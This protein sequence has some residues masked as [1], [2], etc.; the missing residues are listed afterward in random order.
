MLVPETRTSW[1]KD[2]A[3]E[4]TEIGKESGKM[5]EEQRRV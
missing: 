4:A 5:K 2:G 1:R 3:V